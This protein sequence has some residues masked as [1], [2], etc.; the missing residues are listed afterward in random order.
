MCIAK[1]G[2]E[3]QRQARELRSQSQRTREGEREGKEQMEEPGNG[4][5]VATGSSRRCFRG[6]LHLEQYEA[7]GI[8]KSLRDESHLRMG[9]P[10]GRK[11]SCQLPGKS[12]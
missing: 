7:R 12:M 3:Q 2:R 4:R 11:V 9:H 8:M 1:A 6:R 5:C 10:L